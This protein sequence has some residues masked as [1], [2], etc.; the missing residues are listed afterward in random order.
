MFAKWKSTV[1]FDTTI[2]SAA[3]WLLWP[4]AI[5]L[6]TL[7]SVGVSRTPLG[8]SV[9]LDVPGI[10]IYPIPRIFDCR[11]CSVFHAGLVF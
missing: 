1:R 7:T 9:V 8:E 5:K 4:C 3:S 6:S 11:L 2:L 10:A